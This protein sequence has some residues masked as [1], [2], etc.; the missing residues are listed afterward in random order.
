MLG[1][2]G[3]AQGGFTLVEVVVAILILATVM[4]GVTGL[5]YA[6]WQG[7]QRGGSSTVALN[8][9]QEKLE[10]IKN[11]PSLLDD[12]ALPSSY[13]GREPFASP[14]ADYSYWV[15]AVEASQAGSGLKKV[16]VK[17]SY[18]VRGVEQQVSLTTLVRSP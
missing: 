13:D 15:E 6:G 5:L 18:E 1:P 3:D 12:P 11:D 14:Y 2:R 9:A 16:A 4:L 17:V 8:L 7:T 10:E